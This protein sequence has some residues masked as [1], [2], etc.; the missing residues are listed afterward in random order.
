MAIRQVFVNA[1][2]FAHTVA[3][4]PHVEFVDCMV[5]EGETILHVGS[6]KDPLVEDHIQQ[7]TQVI[8]LQDRIVVPGLIDAHTHLL[9]FGLSQQKL[10]LTEI[11]SLDELRSAI[12]QHANLHPTLPR[13]LCR[14]WHQPSTGRQALATMLV[15]MLLHEVYI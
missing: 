15:R 9:F 5:V 12:S 10:D 1:R 14:G 11:R 6:R 8:D 4:S 2:I 13:I 3:A 7:G